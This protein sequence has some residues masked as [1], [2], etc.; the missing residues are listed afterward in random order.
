MRC[1]CGRGTIFLAFFLPDAAR[2]VGGAE[3]GIEAADARSGLPEDGVLG[4]DAQVA[5]DVQDVAA[6][7]GE[8]VDGGDDG[9]GQGADLFLHVEH[10]EARHAVAVEVAAAALDVHVAAGA[11][12]DVAGAGEDDDAHG[13]H[14]PREAQGVAHFC[15]CQ[16]GEGVA[17]AFAVDGDAGDAAVLL[18]EDFFVLLDGKP[19][20]FHGG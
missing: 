14:F 4:G 20:A 9:F 10:G 5:D 15:R 3:A 7:D 8:A 17:V 6:A 1:T 19:I 13:G 2:H 16:G 11:E 12:G 18:E